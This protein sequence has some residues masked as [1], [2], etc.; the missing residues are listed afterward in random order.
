MRGE[1][2]PRAACERGSEPAETQTF[3]LA[4]REGAFSGLCEAMGHYRTL[5]VTPL[6]SLEQTATCT[7]LTQ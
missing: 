6:R 3:G 4:V 5:S 7:L 1:T 2:A